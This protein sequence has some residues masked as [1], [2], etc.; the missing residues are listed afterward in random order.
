MTTQIVRFLKCFCEIDHHRLVFNR[1]FSDSRIALYLIF[2]VF[3]DIPRT[4]LIKS[5]S[6]RRER[7]GGRGEREGGR[8]E[9]EREIE[10]KKERE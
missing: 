2:K 3:N 8:G 6:R 9:R 7:E 5:R 1:L 10:S 4:Y